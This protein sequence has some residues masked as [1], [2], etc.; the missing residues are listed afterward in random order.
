MGQDGRKPKRGKIE[1]TAN[2]SMYDWNPMKS[3]SNPFT[4]FATFSPV[5]VVLIMK[6]AGT[7][8]AAGSSANGGATAGLPNGKSVKFL[9]IW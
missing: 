9:L 2:D 7:L 1:L 4:N 6:S 8:G 3:P 5:M